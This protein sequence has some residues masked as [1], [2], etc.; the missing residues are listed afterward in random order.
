[1]KLRASTS[2]ATASLLSLLLATPLAAQT[3]T[4]RPY[5]EPGD[6]GPF[7][8]R[9]Q[10]VVTWQTDE[11]H[12]LPSAYTVQFGKSSTQLESAPVN[13]RVVDNY[14]SADPQ[15]SGL[16]LPFRYGAHSN[17]TAVL[18]GLEYDTTYQYV[19]TG[20]GL[21]ASGFTSSFHT[22]TT[23]GQFEFQVQG[24]EGYYPGIPGTN[25]PLV[26]IYEA[27]II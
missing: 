24:D 25:P 16:V 21:P 11:S 15:F 26:A 18:Q 17:Y 20:P 6:N 13:A 27:R 22:R 12:P 2:I 10:M 7:G 19:V 8:A 9:D 14:L 23:S 3:V 5:I 4:F 1:M